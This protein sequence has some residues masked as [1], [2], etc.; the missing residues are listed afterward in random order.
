MLFGAI[1]REECFFGG[2]LSPICMKT[3]AQLLDHWEIADYDNWTKAYGVPW[4]IMVRYLRYWS[5]VS[6]TG[7]LML[8]RQ[9]D[10]PFPKCFKVTCEYEPQRICKIV[11]VLDDEKEDDRILIVQMRNLSLLA[12]RLFG[13][14]E[15]LVAEA[16]PFDASVP[17]DSVPTVAEPASTSGTLY[18]TYTIKINSCTQPDHHLN[19]VRRCATDSIGL[20]AERVSLGLAAGD[21]DELHRTIDACSLPV[22]KREDKLMTTTTA[23]KGVLKLTP[24]SAGRSSSAGGACFSRLACAASK[25]RRRKKLGQECERV[26]AETSFGNEEKEEERRRADT[27]PLPGARH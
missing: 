4:E 12:I 14:D 6:D 5:L 17:D 10:G 25:D 13:D 20:L 26:E 24:S 1:N 16:L 9:H 27:L 7:S 23:G 8:V 21:T 22:R 19:I 2:S 18:D 3:A 11:Y 15:K